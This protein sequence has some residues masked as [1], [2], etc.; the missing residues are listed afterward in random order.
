MSCHHQLHYC[1]QLHKTYFIDI[2]VYGNIDIQI[3][4][5]LRWASLVKQFVKIHCLLGLKTRKTKDICCLWWRA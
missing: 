4:G 1:P 3:L 2:D 5:V